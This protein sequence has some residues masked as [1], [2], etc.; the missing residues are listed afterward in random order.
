MVEQSSRSAN[1]VSDAI[2]RTARL[3]KSLAARLLR[4]L[5]LRP[6]QE[7]VLMSLWHDGPQR[8]V[9]LVQTLDS[10]APSMTRS[11]ARLEKVGLVRRHSSPDDR[12]VSIVEASEASLPL[13]PAVEAAWAELEALSASAL[14][15]AQQEQLRDLLARVEASLANDAP[16]KSEPRT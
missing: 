8:M 5:G 6:G 15:P 10:D 3:H 7:L 14:S 4:P 2:F 12:R 16:D 13:R 11:I 1:P 9:D